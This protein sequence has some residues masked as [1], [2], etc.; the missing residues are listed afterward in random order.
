MESTSEYFTRR[1][2]EERTRAAEA[3]SS[4]AR[5]AHLE[6]A[7]RLVNLA[8][9][10]VPWNGGQESRQ[11]ASSSQQATVDRSHV[12]KALSNAFTLPPSGAFGS[13]LQAIS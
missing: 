7:S 4:E 1:A 8:T 5:K 6:L 3:T 2:A 13:L 9:E 11:T 12:S 10:P